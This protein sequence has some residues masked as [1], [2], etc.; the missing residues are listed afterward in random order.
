MSFFFR[1]Q[2]NSYP[3]FKLI[4]FILPLFVISKNKKNNDKNLIKLI[5]T[6][7]TNTKKGNN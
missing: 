6:K 2:L 1:T 7:N 5:K 3:S 4:E